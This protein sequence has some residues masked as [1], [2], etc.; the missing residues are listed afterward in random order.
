MAEDGSPVV[1][2]SG[3]EWD[4]CVAGSSWWNIGGTIVANCVSSVQGRHAGAHGAF[5][6][7]ELGCRAGS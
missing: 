2:V 4:V 6:P 7:Y 1:V 3:H 5:E